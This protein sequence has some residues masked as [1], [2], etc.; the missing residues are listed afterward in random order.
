MTLV[1]MVVALLTLP[2]TGVANA[3]D[4][5]TGNGVV[6]TI[7]AAPPALLGIYVAT[8]TDPVTYQV[9]DPKGVVL[10]NGTVGQ[11]F[12]AQGFGMVLMPG[13]VAFVAG[14]AFAITLAAPT[15]AGTK[16]YPPKDWPTKPEL[17][18]IILVGWTDDDKE[19]LGP[20]GP[21]YDVTTTI[22]VSAKVQ[23]LPEAD[24]AGAAACLAAIGVLKRQIEVAIIA[25]YSL[26]RIINEIGSV[27]SKVDVRNE[28]EQHVGEVTMDFAMKYP[29]LADDFA[30]VMSSPIGE[31]AIF[32]DLLNVADPSGTYV[33]P[34]DYAVEPAP[35]TEG[36]DGRV[37]AGAVIELPTD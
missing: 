4:G 29:Q 36:P 15:G 14:D 16:V 28:G 1:N 35:R 21:Q 19:S 23:S 30:P 2:D 13:T 17:Y 12:A 25:R 34:F 31:I 7:R 37:E 9:T 8:L 3:K 10:G 26:Y 5:N 20:N 27:R 18:P 33:P 22:R 6:Q 32:A 11:G 24:D